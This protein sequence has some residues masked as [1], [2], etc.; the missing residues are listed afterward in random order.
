MLN[1][2]IK[3]QRI[4]FWKPLFL[5]SILIL[6]SQ[7]SQ[8]LAWLTSQDTN[9][10]LGPLHRV[11]AGSVMDVSEVK[12]ASIFMADWN[13]VNECKYFSETDSGG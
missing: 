10:A 6:K 3:V 9:S 5:D 11:D 7:K 13:M 8:S 4:Q 2:L 1:I 12:S